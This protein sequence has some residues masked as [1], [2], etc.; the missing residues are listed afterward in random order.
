LLVVAAISKPVLLAIIS[1]PPLDV[2]TC[3]LKFLSRRGYDVDMAKNKLP[4]EVLEQFR[5]WGAKGGKTGG[6]KR[7][8]GVSQ[9]KRSEI[10]RNAVAAR[11]AKRK[12]RE[13]P[14]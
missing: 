4:A 13:K 1:K 10:A 3:F 14:S 11:E 12:Q 5:K 7:W 8:E 9:E 2:N 6:K